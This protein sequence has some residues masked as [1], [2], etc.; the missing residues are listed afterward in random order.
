VGS[1]TKNFAWHPQWVYV[2]IFLGLLPMLIVAMVLTKRMKVTAPFCDLHRKHW[3]KRGWAVGGGLMALLAVGLGSLILAAGNVVPKDMTGL[4]CG[5]WG[6]LAAVWLVTAFALQLTSIEAREITDSHITLN[7]VSPS[8]VDALIQEREMQPREWRDTDFVKSSGSL[9]C[10]PTLLILVVVGALFT[11]VALAAITTVGENAKKQFPPPAAIQVIDSNNH[12][13]LNSPGGNWTLLSGQEAQKLN[14]LAAAAAERDDGE[15]LGL[16]LVE[17]AHPD[18]VVAG[19]EEEFARAVIRDSQAR[20]K[21]IESITPLVFR[22]VKAVR[23]RY[24][25]TYN[26]QRWRYDTIAFICNGKVYRV[27]C[28][29]PAGTTA[30]DGSTFQ[31]FVDAFQLTQVNED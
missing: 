29:G 15:V 8:F 20:D 18:S 10:M 2:L 24:T 5:G 22:G 25:G 11:I 7:R 28:L 27:H 1:D 30:L 17:N 31:P 13:R 19:G 9:S 14:Q 26:Q 12:F 21:Q 3:T 23:Y 6:I 4:A 16:I